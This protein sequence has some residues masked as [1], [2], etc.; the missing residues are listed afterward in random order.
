[1][2]CANLFTTASFGS[3]SLLPV[4]LSQGGCSESDIGILM[5]A[6]ALSSVL[7]R[8][9]TSVAIDRIGRKRSYSIGTGFMT[10]VPL[11]YWA[12]S[13][14]VVGH[15]VPFLLAR[16]AHGIGLAFCFT[17]VFTF[18][19]DFIP[20]RRLN[21][22]F[23][24]FGISGL[25]GLAMGPV[26]NE[27]VIRAWGFEPFFWATSGFAAL[28]FLIHLP[29]REEWT[30]PASR[31]ESLSF[32]SMFRKSKIV[33][34]SVLA[35]VFGV[36]QAA[37]WNFVAPF[38]EQSGIRFVSFYYIAYSLVAILTRLFGGRLADRLG[39]GKIVPYAMGVNGVGLL[40]LTLLGGSGVLLLAGAL[41][42]CGHGLLFPTLNAVT[43]RGEPAEIRGRLTGIFT[44]SI[45]AGA[46]VGSVLLGYVGEW[47][48]FRALFA[49]AGFASLAGVVLFRWGRN[50]VVPAAPGTLDHV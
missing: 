39:E 37:S 19:A 31:A 34:V 35:L 21:E 18:V 47:T 6:M 4:F 14:D 46:F 50:R 24:L 7:F 28:G 9:W 15:Y 33:M 43:V 23:G 5:G 32:F 16:M 45:D 30:P 12:L 38:A 41:N 2:A 48:G 11:L 40:V 13:G 42:G 3:F 36:G 25:A 10:C 27:M 22:G 17:T 44:G 20:P 29:V 26:V 49:T 8:P 1:L